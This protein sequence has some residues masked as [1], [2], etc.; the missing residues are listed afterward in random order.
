MEQH[1]VIHPGE[2]KKFGVA[3]TQQE[4]IQLSS[5]ALQLHAAQETRDSTRIAQ[6]AEALG[7]FVEGKQRQFGLTAVTF[8][9]EHRTED[10]LYYG[11][12]L[13][14][15]VL[16]KTAQ[17]ARQ[18][19]VHFRSVAEANAWLQAQDRIKV[20][21]MNVKSHTGGG[22]GVHALEIDDI[23]FLIEQLDAPTS[24]RYGFAS[25][26]STKLYVKGSME[27]F[28]KAWAARNPQL[29]YCGGVK[30]TAS[31][32]LAGNRIGYVKFNNEHYFVLFSYPVA[33]NR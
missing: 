33:G 23:C 25:E 22:F 20:L 29:H 32:S 15:R 31:A 8:R 2:L 18:R 13:Y 11:G 16:K 9:P 30:C 3:L 28:A 24:Y 26:Q 19:E 5:L 4:R 10:I 7:Q 27:S 21:N 1:Q 12:I 6:A 14:Q 17:A